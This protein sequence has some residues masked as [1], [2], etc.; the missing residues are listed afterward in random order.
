[1]TYI[2]TIRYGFHG[3]HQEIFY[4]EV[5]QLQLLYNTSSVLLIRQLI[6]KIILLFAVLV[7]INFV[8]SICSY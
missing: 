5:P 3:I 1:M 6:I 4:I 7:T 2:G 8:L